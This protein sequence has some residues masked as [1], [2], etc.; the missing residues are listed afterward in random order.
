MRTWMFAGA[1]LAFSAAIGCGGTDTGTNEE[2]TTA[3]HELVVKT[4][5]F[6]VPPGDSFECFY[7]STK[8]ATD[9]AVTSAVG[10]QAEGGHHIT[11]YYADEDKPVGHHPCSDVEMLGLHQV[12]GA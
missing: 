3:T 4:P 6:D 2:N 10:V 11:L 8:A 7:T 5:E 9:L 12:T 1:A